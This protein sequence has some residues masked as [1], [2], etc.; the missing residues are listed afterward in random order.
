MPLD[1]KADSVDKIIRMIRTK[2]DEFWTRIRET[3]PLELFHAAARRVPA[4]RDFLRK[5]RINPEKI[6]T[7]KDFQEV[8]PVNRR[9]Y[10]REYPIERLCW[11]GTL[12]RPLV[13]T[14]TS[15]S[16]GEPFYFPRDEALDWQ[17]TVYHEMFLMNRE[18][19]KE[20]STLAIVCFG[21]GVWIG[22]LITYQA[23]KKIS[24]RGY[25]I[26]ILTP[27]SNKKEIFDAVRHL[28]H[29]F[30]QILLCGY[31]PFIKDVIDEG[32]DAGIE[33][34]DYRIK[35][36]F[37]AEGFS[38]DF[39]NYVM[40]ETNIRQ[41]YLD[42]MNIYGSADLGTM[43]EETPLSILIRRYAV[44]RHKLFEDM[45]GDGNRL[46]T[47]VQFNPYFISFESVGRVITCTGNSVLPLIRYEIGDHG[48]VHSFREV[49]RVFKDYGVDLRGEAKRHEIGE[50]FSE[51]P[52]VS[53]YERSDLSTKFYGAI[54][55]PEHIRVGVTHSSLE[56]H[57]TGKFTMMT[58]YDSRQN[59]YLEI[60]LELRPNVKVSHDLKHR[61]RSLITRKL[62]EKNAE[63]KYLSDMMGDRTLPKII[64]WRHE[65]PLHFK[66]G[67]KQKWVK[68]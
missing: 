61:A 7:F 44:R 28:G 37:A 35:L 3:R 64:T 56:K 36:I 47:L 4:Y 49:N 39:R 9:N 24:R 25:P 27:G 18:H 62:L 41:P 54:I 32:S 5:N 67:G 20:R 33:W 26:S 66:P 42:T 13:F 21:M 60:N 68:K 65:H 11:D 23:L 15:G 6:K 57:L 46:P 8:P 19:N 22:G 29:K 14:A 58:K 12:A 43:A 52:F 50:M 17:S 48:G 63:Y 53:I 45:F 34:H 59:Q 31:P 51:M 10:L 2:K 55:Y 30:D 38:E 16:T 40:R 1:F